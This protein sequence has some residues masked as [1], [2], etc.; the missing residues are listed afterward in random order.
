[1]K[2]LI[3]NLE[4]IF[5][6]EYEKSLY[7]GITMV[8]KD[9]PILKKV[10]IEI[11]IQEIKEIKE[12]SLAITQSVVKENKVIYSIILNEE[13]FKYQNIQDKIDELTYSPT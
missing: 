10:P 5:C 3:I 8:Y 9:F 6:K 4:G 1:M 13:A 2:N 12:N 7:K 11:N